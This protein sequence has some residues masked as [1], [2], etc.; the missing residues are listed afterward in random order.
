MKNVIVISAHPDDETLGVGGT[1][2]RHVANGDKVFWL[3]ITNVFE[4]QG[5]SEER[6]SSRQEEIKK[7]EEMFGIT[8]T[9]ML[10]YPTMSLSSSSIIDMVPKI[11]KVFGI[12]LKYF[13]IFF[14][15]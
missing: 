2:L 13:S 6:V 8:K 10:N 11:S 14:I 15:Y 5:F 9:F 12:F 1:V 4:E 3:I 7:V